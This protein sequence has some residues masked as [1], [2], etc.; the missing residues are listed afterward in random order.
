MPLI[1]GIIQS[2]MM[3]K[4]VVWLLI[5]ASIAAPLENEATLNPNLRSVDSMIVR[6]V[7][8]S[9]AIKTVFIGISLIGFTGAI[10][11]QFQYLSEIQFVDL[12]PA[13]CGEFI[14]PKP[15]SRG[16]LMR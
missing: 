13:T 4:G 3:T 14:E 11:G 15:V 2:T 1:S 8:L 12:I 7:L 16:V 6:S 9:S 5:A 10:L